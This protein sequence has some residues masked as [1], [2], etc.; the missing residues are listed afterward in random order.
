VRSS[1][2]AGVFAPVVVPSMKSRLSE[3][4]DDAENWIGLTMVGCGYSLVGASAACVPAIR[5]YRGLF[6]RRSTISDLIAPLLNASTMHKAYYLENEAI[7]Q[8]RSRGAVGQECV[9]YQMSVFAVVA[10]TVVVIGVSVSVFQ[11]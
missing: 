9:V 5:V 1:T 11:E 7:S 3:E 6:S 4:D 8:S 2:V 10:D